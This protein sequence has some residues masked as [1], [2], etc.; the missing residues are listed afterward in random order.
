M[1]KVVFFITKLGH[2]GAERVATIVANEFAKDNDYE[3][4]VVLTYDNE[5]AYKLDSRIKTIIL[6]FSRNHFIRIL[7]R[8]YKI[9]KIL[10][11]I[12]PDAVISIPEGTTPILL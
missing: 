8:Q 10:R 11:V 2:G 5:N 9:H 1:K 4:F 12:K 3:V 7:L 6:P